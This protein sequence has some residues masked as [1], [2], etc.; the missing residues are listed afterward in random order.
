VRSSKPPLQVNVEALP[1]EQPLFRDLEVAED[2]GDPQ[3]QL[4]AFTW[5]DLHVAIAEQRRSAN[6]DAACRRHPHVNIAEQSKDAEVAASSGRSAPQVQLHVADE[7]D[8]ALV[9][10]AGGKRVFGDVSDK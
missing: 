3:L 1:V 2:P 7:E 10:P 9:R 4:R 6:R 5:R 8:D